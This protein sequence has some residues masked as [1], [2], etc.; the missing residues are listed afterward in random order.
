[1]GNRKEIVP[2]DISNQYFTDMRQNV[3]L[4]RFRFV[5]GSVRNRFQFVLVRFRF[6]SGS[7]PD[8]FRFGSG[9]V[10]VRFRFDSG[11]V[12]VWFQFTL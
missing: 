6:S 2:L 12:P 11:S 9:S 8:L 7:V 10:P 3:N 1:M 5:S 4:V